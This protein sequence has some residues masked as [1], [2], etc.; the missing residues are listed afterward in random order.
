MD[1][2]MIARMVQIGI[3]TALDTEDRR[4]RVKFP[5]T[6]MTSGWL[7]VLRHGLDWM[8]NINDVVLIV[9]IPV[10]NSDGFVVGVV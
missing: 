4:C 6:G 9:Y 2:S 8:P 3:V 1:E 7:R 10:F 5:D